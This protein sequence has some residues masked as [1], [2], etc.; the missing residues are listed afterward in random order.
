MSSRIRKTVAAT[1]VA[2]SCGLALMIAPA[3][4]ST[5]APAHHQTA[6]QAARACGACPIPKL[7]IT[8]SE[9]ADTDAEVVIKKMDP[10]GPA[11]KAG[12]DNGDVLQFIDSAETVGSGTAILDP[13]H[14]NQLL[15]DRASG[16]Q[17]KFQ[18]FK[19][20]ERGEAYIDVTI[21]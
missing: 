19:T 16:T 1:A 6:A 18:V 12:L 3:Q 10:D 21:N 9:V 4:A 11:S 14:L 2:A 20:A 15:K 7:G 17:V 5:P 8:E 13:D